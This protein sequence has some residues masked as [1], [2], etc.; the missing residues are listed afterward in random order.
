MSITIGGKCCNDHGPTWQSDNID[1]CTIM[2]TPHDYYHNE[3]DDDNDDMSSSTK[4]NEKLKN[5][6][7]GLAKL[8]CNVYQ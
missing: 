5:I 1:R 6:R 4:Q 8:V 7:Y 2:T 3:N